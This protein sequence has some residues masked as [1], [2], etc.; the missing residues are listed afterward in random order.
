MLEDTPYQ[1]PQ[2]KKGVFRNQN[3]DIGRVFESVPRQSGETI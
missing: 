1:S 3:S 2:L